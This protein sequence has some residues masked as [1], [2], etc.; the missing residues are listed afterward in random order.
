M[1]KTDGNTGLVRAIGRWSLTA[2]VI[3]AVLGSGIFGLPDDVARLVGEAAPWAYLLAATAIGLI[4]A[5]FAEVASQFREAGGPYLYARE[6]FGPFAG[7]QMGW[8]AWLVRL[9][10]AAANANLFAVYLAEFFPQTTEGLI[11]ILVL[12]FLIGILA[13]VNVRGVKSG[14]NVS[15]AF[16]FTKLLPLLILISIGL[17]LVGGDIRVGTGIASTNQWLQAILVLV[18]A[19]GGFEASM[20]PMSEVKDPRRQ[21]PFAL[22]TGLAVITILYLLVQ[23][24][25]M[26]AFSN[27]ASFELPEVRERPV[28]E[29]ARVFL[30]PAGSVF[31]AVCVLIS[32][33]GYLSG[34]FVSAP[35]LTYAFA[36]Q[37]DFP[38]FFAAVHP[39][40]RTPHVSIIVYAML[41]WA[42]A[43]YGSFIWNAILSA[44]ARLFTYAF[45]CGSLIALRRSRPDVPSFRLPGGA[46]IA[47]AGIAFC[48]VLITQM[49]KQHL[50]IMLVISAAATLNWMR[51]KRANEPRSHERTSRIHKEQ[52]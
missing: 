23:L 41:V 37:R 10:S 14:A 36:E 1:A 49:G 5:C 28:A 51:A 31:V 17:A 22:F 12:T 8:F 35:R 13:A 7:I 25:I 26:G 42:L 40:F 27:P 15:N 4:M 30:G 6:A 18:F 48:A 20:M 52:S 46:P 43:V 32:I 47:I 45:V 33:Y 34:Q 29:A 16:V 9:T 39:R 50:M 21:A 24:V 44:V 3:N 19:Y 2:L 38:S 11:R